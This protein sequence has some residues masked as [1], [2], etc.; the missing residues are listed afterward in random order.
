M[1]N[2]LIRKKYMSIVIEEHL[3]Y[4]LH[5]VDYF[6]DIFNELHFYSNQIIHIQ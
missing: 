5:A 3:I 2:K 1:E 4:I 6:T